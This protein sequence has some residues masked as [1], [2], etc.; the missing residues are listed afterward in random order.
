MFQHNRLDSDLTFIQKVKNLDYILLS[1]IMLLSVISVFVM[2]STDGGELLYH[3]KSHII[4]FVTFFLMM[5]FLSFL[6]IL[7]NK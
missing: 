3:S 7:L 6:N 2:Y 1:S 4:R 5:I